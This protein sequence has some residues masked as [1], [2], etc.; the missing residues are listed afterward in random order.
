[1]I[2]LHTAN[3]IGIDND[4]NGSTVNTKNVPE[5]Q[6]FKTVN[7]GGSQKQAMSLPKG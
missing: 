3:W 4:A 5:F 7:W 2:L 6:A 1:M